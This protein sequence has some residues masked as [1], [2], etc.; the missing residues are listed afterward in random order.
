M[1]ISTAPLVHF[2]KPGERDRV[3]GSHCVSESK[4]C[5]IMFLMTKDLL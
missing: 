5:E 2:P 3:E 1:F 4:A